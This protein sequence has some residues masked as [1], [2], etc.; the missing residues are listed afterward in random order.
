MWFHK[1]H[2]DK[3]FIQTSIN[4][5]KENILLKIYFHT[6]NDNNYV[7]SLCIKMLDEIKEKFPPK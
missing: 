2:L 4:V 6:K 5:L 3:F 1:K 7:G